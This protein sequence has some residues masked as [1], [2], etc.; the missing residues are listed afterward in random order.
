MLTPEVGKHWSLEDLRLK[1]PELFRTVATRGG[2][3]VVKRPILRNNHWNWVPGFVVDC[4]LMHEIVWVDVHFTEKEFSSMY[5]ILEHGICTNAKF[6]AIRGSLVMEGKKLWPTGSL[7]HMAM[8]QV[9]VEAMLCLLYGQNLG[10][11]GVYRFMRSVVPCL[12]PVKTRTYYKRCDRK[13]QPGDVDGGDGAADEDTGHAVSGPASGGGPPGAEPQ[14][15][16]GP[17]L[18]VPHPGL[19]T[20]EKEVALTQTGATARDLEVLQNADET[21]RVV[22]ED[23]M[24]K[25]VGREYDKSTDKFPIVGVQTGPCLEPPLVYCNTFENVEAAVHNRLELKAKPCTWTRADKEK[26][27]AFARA[28]CIGKHAVFSRERVQD[29]IVR[30]WD[31]E[32]IKSGKWSL[33]RLQSSLENL[34][35]QAN[36]SFRLSAAIKAEVMPTGKAPR[37][38]IADGD[39]GQLMALLTVKCFEDI[40][41]D[42]F[43]KKSIK[44]A[45]KRDAVDRCVGELAPPKKL[46]HE[47][48]AIEGDGTAWDTTCNPEV[49]S[50]ENY[51]LWHIANILGELGV[52]PQAWHD[53][54]AQINDKKQ[55]K[56][57]FR[58]ACGNVVKKISAIRRSGHRGTS[59]LNWWTN[60]AMW[61]CSVFQQPHLF[62]DPAVRRGDDVLGHKRWFNGCF[63]G[64]DSLIMTSPKLEQG[65]SITD[66]VLGYW[67]RAGFNMKFVFVSKRATF[68]GWHVAAINGVL[69]KGKMAPELPRALKSNVSCSAG[70]KEA[71]KSGDHKVARQIAAAAMLARAADFA[72]LLPTVSRKYQQYASTLADRDADIS[73][74]ELTMR[75]SN[76]DDADV[77]YR[78]VHDLVDTRNLGTDPAVEKELLSALGLDADDDELLRFQTFQWDWDALNDYEGFAASVPQSWK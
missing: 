14:P 43:E 38:L 22:M 57:F 76:S 5:H 47:A 33:N 73:D 59:C 24:I 12:P 17:G 18:T 71:A 45:V 30:S 65:T 10:E 75:V 37:L 19:G 28:A 66:A 29:W 67:D 56:V 9:G 62:L 61:Y 50:S 48:G 13:D 25:V 64:D 31:F 46:E 54:H 8:K 68:V 78:S 36:P 74:R 3:W 69:S 77:T 4:C 49:R 20:D 26:Y 27:L 40:L 51:V 23:S 21:L 52:A 63:E 2:E 70:M 41:F 55:L 32:E 7:E 39:D 35:R 15:E 58:G 6:T 60:Y 16:A 53:A 72:G 34:Y 42:H 1:T 44:H 11:R